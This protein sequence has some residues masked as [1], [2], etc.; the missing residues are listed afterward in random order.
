MEG[1]PNQRSKVVRTIAAAVA[2]GFAVAFVP[3]PIARL[4]GKQESEGVVWLASAFAA[5]VLVGITAGVGAATIAGTDDPR[6]RAG[7][8]VLFATMIAAVALGVFAG[9]LPF[10]EDRQ[11]G[12]GS[13]LVVSVIAAVFPVTLGTLLGYARGTNRRLRD[14]RPE[15]PAE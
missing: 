3:S 13:L 10:E 4:I 12:L 14:H 9:E 1:Q 7:V 11:A 6:R 8:V 15:P 5:L 2:F